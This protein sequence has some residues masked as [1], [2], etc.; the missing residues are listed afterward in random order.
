MKVNQMLMGALTS[1]A[2]VP[3]ILLVCQLLLD[4]NLAL[5][6]QTALAFP[7]KQS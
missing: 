4:S 3:Q 1:E 7:L 2:S 6:L 5:L